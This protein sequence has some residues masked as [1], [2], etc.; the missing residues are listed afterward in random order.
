LIWHSF[1]SN[2]L[3]FRVEPYNGIILFGIRTIQK[4]IL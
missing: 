3:Y 4:A 1:I 2:V